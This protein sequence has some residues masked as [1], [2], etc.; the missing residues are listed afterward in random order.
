MHVTLVVHVLFHGFVPGAWNILEYIRQ[1][2]LVGNVMVI[3]QSLSIV[4][5]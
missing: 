3:R 4:G 5:H 1:V 2:D